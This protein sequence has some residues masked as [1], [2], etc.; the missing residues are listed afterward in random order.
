MG[1]Y[2]YS[3]TSILHIYYVLRFWVIIIGEFKVFKLFG[4]LIWWLFGLRFIWA[5]IVVLRF[6]GIHTEFFLYKGM[7]G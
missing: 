1:Y 4:V 3:L 5:Y 6:W 2:I 7:D